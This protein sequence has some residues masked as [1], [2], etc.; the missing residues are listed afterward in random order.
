MAALLSVRKQAGNLSPVFRGMTA[1]F[2]VGELVDGNVL[3][4]FRLEHRDT[5]VEAEGAVGGATAPAPSLVTDGLS[6]RFR[7]A[8]AFLP[9]FDRQRQ[10]LCGPPPVLCSNM[11][12]LGAI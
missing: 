7:P 8:H 5:P 3:S 2:Q 1:D 4:E 6:R 11:A 10:T 12:P 9:E